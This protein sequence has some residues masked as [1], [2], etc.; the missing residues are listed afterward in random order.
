MNRSLFVFAMVSLATPAWPCTV[1]GPLPSAERLVQDA[2]VVARVRAEDVAST[3][4][5]GGFFLDA[6]PTQVRFLIIEVL[7]GELSTVVI[8]FNG[9]LTNRDDR[10]D[11]PVPYARIRRGGRGGTCYA[12]TYRAGAEYLLFLRPGSRG[13]SQEN[14]LTPY[15]APLGPTNEQLFG[16]VS[17]AWLLWVKEQLRR[18]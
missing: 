12:L 7:K 3:P 5:S 13:S 2:Q 17:D 8:E 1:V 4:G 11:G 15:W 14:V 10:N 6:S 16:G 9:S 18:Q